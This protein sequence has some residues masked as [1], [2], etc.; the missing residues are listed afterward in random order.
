[1]LQRFLWASI[2]AGLL[3]G[4][5]TALLDGQTASPQE[6]WDGLW[7]AA[8]FFGTCMGIARIAFDWWDARQERV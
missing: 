2:P 4:A 6:F 8:L 3:F 5:L 7:P 1:M